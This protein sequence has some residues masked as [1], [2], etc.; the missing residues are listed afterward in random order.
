LSAEPPAAPVAAAT[1]EAEHTFLRLRRDAAD[2]P[3]ALETAIVRYVPNKPGREGLTVDLVGA[4][5]VGDKGYYQALNE[6]F[7]K[8]DVVLYELLAPAGTRIPKGGG[9]NSNNPISSLQSGLK[10]LLELELQLECVDYT[11]DNLVHADMSPK[12]FLKSMEERG[13]SFWTL[14]FRLM[15]ESM[16]QQSKLESQG[17]S[18]DSTTL[19]FALMSKDRS[20]AL[21][22]MMAEQFDIMGG[23]LRSLEGPEGSTLV[24][25]RNKVALEGLTKQI[26]AGK[27]KIAIFYGAAHLADME[28]RLLAD[29]DLQR[30]DERWLTA[31]DLSGKPPAPPA[32]APAQEEKP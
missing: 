12:D 30:T 14:F 17:K 7:E 21:K 18:L 27:K 20:S 23:G 19:L 24:T 9:R 25:E 6:A 1:K 2:K 13:E 16:A 22:A 15:G 26:T 8:Y 10:S 5:H 4:V 31:W 32:A 11:K 28:K 29:F 3:L